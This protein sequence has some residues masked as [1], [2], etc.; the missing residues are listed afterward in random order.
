MSIIGTIYALEGGAKHMAII[1]AA[2]LNSVTRLFYI[3][4][5][6]ALI[7][8]TTGKISVMCLIKRLQSPQRWRSIIL[9]V[10]G[11]LLAAYNSINIILLFVACND[12]LATWDPAA[13]PTGHCL[14]VAPANIN[15][16][17]GAGMYRLKHDAARSGLHH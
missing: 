5:L 6:F 7:C 13:S 10:L 4:Q 3:Y 17:A 9:W 12:L 2:Q 8:L 14:S 15:A 1:S 11:I 16:L